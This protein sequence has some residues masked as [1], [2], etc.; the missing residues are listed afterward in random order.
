MKKRIK[1][2]QRRKKTEEAPRTIRSRRAFEEAR[3]ETLK[4]GGGWT[5]AEREYLDRFH[6]YYGGEARKG[7]ARKLYKISHVRRSL[8]A[9]WRYLEKK[10]E[11][12]IGQPVDK[13][14]S[15]LSLEN[16]LEHH[17][18]IAK[19]IRDLIEENKVLEEKAQKME[20]KIKKIKERDKAILLINK[21][22]IALA[23]TIANS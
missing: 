10:R 9:I 19:E 14:K 6:G 16:F 12:A 23:A 8:D 15:K 13:P 2:S 7:I 4:K 22:L 21:E 18:A 11:A 1:E 20:K 5:K 17:D 3:K